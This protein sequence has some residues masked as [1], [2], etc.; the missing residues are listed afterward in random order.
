M[1]RTVATVTFTFAALAICLGLSAAFGAGPLLVAGKP[2]ALVGKPGKLDFMAYDLKRDRILATHT[3][4]HHLVV[5]DAKAK[6]VLAA[7]EVG[8]AQGVAVDEEAGRYFAGTDDGKSVVLI[9]AVKFTIIGKIDVGAPV[10][11]MVFDPKNHRLYAAADDGN[12]LWV[13]DPSQL[14]IVA[15]VA[16]PGVPE[17]LSYDL[18]L[19]RLFL[20]IKDKDLLV[21]INPETNAV[22][23]T[24]STLPA[25]SPH[26]LV[27]DRERS[28]AYVAGRNSQLVSIDLSSGN[29]LSSTSIGEGNDQI[30]FDSKS[31]RLYS[32]CKN[33]ISVTQ[34]SDSGLKPLGDEPI[35]KGAHSV[36]FSDVSQTIWITYSDASKSYAL[37]LK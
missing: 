37:P 3:S 26:G 24:W 7:I 22:E 8:D 4:A 9:D 11:A 16:I 20:N 23:A 15:K 25:K 10:D 2:I 13:I 6:Q 18:K 14:K 12:Q 5:I 35:P 19:D 32:A 28:R 33:K 29:H 17:G 27:L 21:R 1:I 36:A 31:Q 34:V 30:A